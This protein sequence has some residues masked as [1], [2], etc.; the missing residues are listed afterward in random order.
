MFVCGYIS[1]CTYMY[2]SREEREERTVSFRIQHAQ[3]LLRYRTA[4]KSGE[5]IEPIGQLLH[6]FSPPRDQLLVAL[7][8]QDVSHT[9]PRRLIRLKY[10]PEPGQGCVSRRPWFISSGQLLSPLSGFF[11]PPSPFVSCAPLATRFAAPAVFSCKYTRG[12]AVH[13]SRFPEMKKNV[14]S[15]ARAPDLYRRTPK[16]N[17]EISFRF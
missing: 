15:Y 16:V 4:T 14:Q 3:V 1:L 2:T 6:P 11:S 8:V 9:N 17:C 10:D 5:K 13:V 12:R 7:R